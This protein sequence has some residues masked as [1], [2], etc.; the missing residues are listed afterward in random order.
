[1]LP[2]LVAPVPPKIAR[3][4]QITKEK[5]CWTMLALIS[6]G[7]K[8]SSLQMPLCR[9]RRRQS[10]GSEVSGVLRSGGQAGQ[11]RQP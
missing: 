8:P 11:E 5:P 4:N 7:K 1:M 10:A 3:A 9:Q 2:G 6:T